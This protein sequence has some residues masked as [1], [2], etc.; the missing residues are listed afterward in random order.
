MWLGS[1]EDALVAGH[2]RLVQRGENAKAQCGRV[3]V[4]ETQA[5]N[6]LDERALEVGMLVLEHQWHRVEIAL[7]ALDHQIPVPARANAGVPANRKEPP[8]RVV[9]RIK[10]LPASK[11]VQ[12]GFLRKVVGVRVVPREREREAGHI[13]EPRQHEVLKTGPRRR[14]RLCRVRHAIVPSSS[15]SNTGQIV[16]RTLLSSIGRYDRAGF[17][18]AAV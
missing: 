8:S 17:W 7:V 9:A 6:S 16:T 11:C 2:A 15:A 14:S 10:C 3:G 5:L 18:S 1:N 12:K 4:R 13:L